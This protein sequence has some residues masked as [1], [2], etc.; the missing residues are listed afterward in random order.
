MIFPSF[1]RRNHNLVAGW[2]K[3]DGGSPEVAGPVQLAFW[4]KR[5][6]L[7]ILHR[8]ETFLLGGEAFTRS[9]HLLGTHTVFGSREEDD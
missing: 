8:K 2:K 6:K 5:A 4:L 7:V 9:S 3:D 1:S